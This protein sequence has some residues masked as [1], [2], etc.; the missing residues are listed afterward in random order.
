MS[1]EGNDN[2]AAEIAA[3]AQP[4]LTT[5]DFQFHGKN[6]STLT[7]ED[8]LKSCNCEQY[9]DKFREEGCE[10]VREIGSCSDS[11]LDYICSRLKIKLFVKIKLKS[12]L[13]RLRE[14]YENQKIA[15]RDRQ[16]GGRFRKALR[17]NNPEEDFEYPIVIIPQSVS[18]YGPEWVQK[19]EEYM[20]KHQPYNLGIVDKLISKGFVPEGTSDLDPQNEDDLSWLNKGCLRRTRFLHR[21]IESNILNYISAI[22]LKAGGHRF[23]DGISRVSVTEALA[24]SCFI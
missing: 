22:L 6:L 5:R 7:I 3:S 8:F 19:F 14:C 12:E 23:L 15:R 1:T 20:E 4:K 17:R 2:S 11:D 24:C 21:S 18:C 9:A 16:G 13:R 10:S